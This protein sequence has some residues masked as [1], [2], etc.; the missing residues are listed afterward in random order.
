MYGKSTRGLPGLG[1]AVVLV[2]ACG[3]GGAATPTP[4]APTQ[5]ATQAA[6]TAPETA[7]PSATNP[8][9]GAPSL[10]APAS[11]PSG[12][13]FSVTWTGPNAEKDYITIVAA[14]ATKWTNEDYFYTNAGSPGKLTAVTTPGAYEL[15]YVSGKD[16]TVLVK[17]P[18]TIAPFSGSL[19]APDTVG[20]NTEF[21]VA[22]TGSNGPGD[23]I[24]IVKLGVTKW[25]NERY[26]Y[27]KDANPGKL[28][29]PVEAGSYEVWY[30]AADGTVQ[31]RRPITV[32][33]V[34]ATLKAAAEVAKGT[35]FPVE[36]TGPAG[37]GDYVTIA[38]AGSPQTT[39][40]TY[41]YTTAASPGTLTAPDTAGDYELRYVIGQST[42]VVATIAIKVR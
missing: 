11:V 34:T 23:Y 10:D 4:A 24:T 33:A 5:A 7:G 13:E 28:L 42:V 17:R 29:A 25:S 35:T 32:T 31:V 41:F 14:G 20:G 37:P 21:Q 16:S 3:G 27:T 2:A 39:Y 1:L 36:W 12:T 26:F 30:V 40:L 22:W 18:I 19:T 15:W 8:S 38:P 6:T 9:T